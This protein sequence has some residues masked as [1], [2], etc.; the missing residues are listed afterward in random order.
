[1]L[2]APCHGCLHTHAGVHNPA[3]HHRPITYLTA[4]ILLFSCE[5]VSKLFTYKINGRTSIVITHTV[6]PC[7]NSVVVTETSVLHS[8]EAFIVQEV[9]TYFILHIHFIE[10]ILSE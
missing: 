8:I 1:M 10:V 7:L 4:Q 2:A 6:L 9:K 5:S 3:T